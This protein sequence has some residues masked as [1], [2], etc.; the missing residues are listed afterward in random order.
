MDCIAE[1]SEADAATT[2]PVTRRVFAGRTSVGTDTIIADSPVYGRML[3]L[4]G[5][6]QSAA[7]DEHVYHETLVHPVMA[8]ALRR[9]MR[10]LVIG[11]GEGATVREVL[12]WPDLRSVD[13]VDYDR[14][15]V[16]LCREHLCWGSPE[17][18]DAT[19]VR[20]RAADIG[21]AWPYLAD[22]YDVIILDLPD[23]DG[24]TGY[25]YSAQFW[26]D[27]RQHLAN[28]GFLVTHCGPVRPFG[29]IG[30]GFLRVR[31]ALGDQPEG[32]YAQPI[33]SFQGEW[34]FWIWS[35]AGGDP[36][37]G[38]KGLLNLATPVGLRVADSAQ[39]RAWAER[40]RVWR[41]AL[42]ALETSC[43]SRLAA[44]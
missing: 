34:G 2:Y 21:Q 28:D 16:N 12:R 31:E 10:V 36:F 43:L 41:T 38:T 27:V 1:V 29:I 7:A 33:A 32:F 23:P 20:Y 15:L 11:G 14:D 9:Q 37:A 24:D 22:A 4:D 17:V 35:K 44:L 19:R 42:T 26:E 6:L 30:E 8:L 18:Y 25:L 5:E 3:F 13:W 40:S 39:I